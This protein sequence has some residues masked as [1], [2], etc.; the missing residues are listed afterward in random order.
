MR[1][2]TPLTLLVPAGTPSSAPVSAAW[3]L[4]PGWIGRIRVDIPA[5]HRALTGVRLLW[6]GTPVIPFDP[7]AYLTGNG[8]TFH[9]DFEDAY[10]GF[11]MVCQ[12]FNTDVWPHTFRLWAD[13]NPHRDGISAGGFTRPRRPGQHDRMLAAVAALERTSAAS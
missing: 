10:D 2:Y 11:G 3:S 4:Y 7:A 9:V 5:G 1:Q 6:H 12:G 13:V 8:H